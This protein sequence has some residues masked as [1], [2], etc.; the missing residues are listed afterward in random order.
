MAI[1]TIATAGVLGAYLAITGGVLV[2]WNLGRRQERSR[3]ADALEP[4]RRKAADDDRLPE[5]YPDECAN[6]KTNAVLAL[7][8]LEL[9]TRRDTY[10]HAI[11][12]AEDPGR[13]E[14]ASA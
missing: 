9:A 7:I 12:V 5:E 11:S 6:I 4:E 2:S 3:I 10:A 1:E 14:E 13:G 8:Q